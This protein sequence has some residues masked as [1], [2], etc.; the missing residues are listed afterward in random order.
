MRAPVLSFATAAFV[1]AVAC[2][3]QSGQPATTTAQE[4]PG[5]KT[6]YQARCAGARVVSNYLVP[7]GV[8]VTTVATS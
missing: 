3:G 7:S 2:G 1:L 6:E 8:Q 4:P 5:P